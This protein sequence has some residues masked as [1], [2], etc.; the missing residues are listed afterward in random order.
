LSPGTTRPLVPSAVATAAASR[1]PVPGATRVNATR[2]TAIHP[3][4]A[5]TTT[6]VD[7]ASPS[8]VPTE[9]RQRLEVFFESL[10]SIFPQ[11][12]EADLLRYTLLEAYSDPDKGN[13]LRLNLQGWCAH[14][15]LSPTPS[16]R[17]APSVRRARPP[18]SSSSSQ[19]QEGEARPTVEPTQSI[20]RS[21]PSVEFDL[22]VI[23]YQREKE[24][25]QQREQR[26]LARTVRHALRAQG[27]R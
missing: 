9:P 8:L 5:A 7:P 10:S 21:T 14:L 24:V 17:Q 26:A 4:R 19:D 27:I 6:I 22:F 15:H 1:L 2:T 13:V 11:L 23:N 16:E 18:E 20:R 3:S 25:S 12:S